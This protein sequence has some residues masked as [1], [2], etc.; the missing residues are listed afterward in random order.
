MS[1]LPGRGAELRACLSDFAEA[2]GIDLTELEV[3]LMELEMTPD[4]IPEVPASRL[5]DITGA[6]EGR[7]RKF[8]MYCRTWQVRLEAKRTQHMEKRRRLD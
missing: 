6:V 2:S 7:V 1:P 5:C 4:I 3:P 8:Q